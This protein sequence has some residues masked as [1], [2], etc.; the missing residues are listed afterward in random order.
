MG[1]SQNSVKNKNSFAAP[2]EDLTLIERTT[3]FGSDL[4]TIHG[5]CD[6]FALLAEDIQD[7]RFI[8]VLSDTLVKSRGTAI[9]KALAV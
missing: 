8:A 9:L 4:R 3:G 2:A 6:L 1:I 7:I 5:C